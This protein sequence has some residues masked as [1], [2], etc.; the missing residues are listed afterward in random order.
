MRESCPWEVMS[1][2]SPCALSETGRRRR[3]R[4]RG[5][6]GGLRHLV[7][8]IVLGRRAG[9]PT[10]DDG[11][12]LMQLRAAQGFLSGLD[13]TE[14]RRV[15]LERR[16]VV[17][18]REIVARFPRLVVPTYLGDEAWFASD[19]FRSLLPDDWPVEFKRLEEVIHP[20]LLRQ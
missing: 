11:L 15:E 18:D 10:L 13:E 7:A 5:V 8:R 1:R 2:H 20:E 9:A 4:E 12:L 17:P 3:L 14:K 6:A 16:R 19:A